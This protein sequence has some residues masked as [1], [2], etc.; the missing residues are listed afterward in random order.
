[1]LQKCQ[2]S[3]GNKNINVI[4]GKTKLLCIE[5]LVWV[6]HLK[7]GMMGSYGYCGWSGKKKKACL[8]CKQSTSSVFK[9]RS[10]RFQ[11]T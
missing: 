7:I 4:K 2:G 6:S 3:S 1:M 5:Y 8:N 10:S 11:S 9:T